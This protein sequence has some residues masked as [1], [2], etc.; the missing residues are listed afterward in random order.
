MALRALGG[1]KRDSEYSGI[2][3]ITWGSTPGTNFRVGHSRNYVGT[4]SRN[5]PEILEGGHS[6]HFL[7][8]F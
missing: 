6:R 7:E 2:K 3:A 1:E 8:I 5:V 4:H